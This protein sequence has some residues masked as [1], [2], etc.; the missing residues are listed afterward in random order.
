MIKRFDEFIIE[1]VNNQVLNNPQI[2]TRPKNN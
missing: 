2:I 1:D